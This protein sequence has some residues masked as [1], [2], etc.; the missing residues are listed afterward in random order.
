MQSHN[1]VTVAKQDVRGAVIAMA[2]RLLLPLVRIFIRHGFSCQE[3]TELTRWAFVQ[4][5]MHDPEFALPSRSRQ[6]KSR[7]AVL[8]GLSRKEILRLIQFTD[9]PDPESLVCA[10]RAARV[11]HGWTQDADFRDAGGRPRVLPIKGSDDSFHALVKKYSGDV[12]PRAVLDELRRCDAV[13]VD[14]GRV[15]LLRSRHTATDGNV[16]A[17]EQATRAAGNLLD[18]LDRNLQSGAA[19]VFQQEVVSQRIP[20]ASA[21]AVKAEIDQRAAAF[22]REIR[23]LLDEHE[24]SGKGA[25]TRVG[26]GS[27]RV[28][29]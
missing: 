17:L 26:F 22:S 25:R 19:P 13:R 23:Q 9:G 3:F 28:G 6:F 11:L 14:A 16:A 10:N 29:A 5:A 12:P 1:K 18:V 21:P 2:Q 20:V 8:T 15:E 7:A 24:S 27:Y 4:A